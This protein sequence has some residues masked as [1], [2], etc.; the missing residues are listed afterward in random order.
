MK[1]FAIIFAAI[2][3]IFL[4]SAIAAG[5]VISFTVVKPTTKAIN[6][7]L[8]EHFAKIVR[9][10]QGIL[11]PNVGFDLTSYSWEME[12]IE[13]EVTGVKFS[14]N[15]VFV[16]S[17]NVILATLEMPEGGDV[18]IFN[19]V[20]PAV[21]ADK[22]SVDSAI[23]V[24]K[25]NLSANQDA[26]YSK[27]NLSVKPETKQTVKITWEYDKSKLG[28]DLSQDYAKLAKY[29]PSLLRIFDGLPHLIIGL[30]GG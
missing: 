16:R 14:Y 10:P 12:T 13:K 7:K 11:P 6:Q 22:Q 3:A 20:L 25:A 29:P 17:Q 27:I 5:I 28:N 15:P 18:S 9:I 21:V 2:V 4:I 30:L 23:N 24:E 1:K 8:V 26:G 19:K